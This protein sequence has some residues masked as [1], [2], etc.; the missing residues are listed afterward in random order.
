MIERYRV[1]IVVALEAIED[2]DA[3][4]AVAILLNALESEP[5][6]DADGRRRRCEVCGFGPAWPG[7]LSA[8]WRNVHD[9]DR[10]GLERAA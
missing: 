6:C 9:G 7:E 2:G 5:V 3:A 10:L 1:A 4:L 8:H